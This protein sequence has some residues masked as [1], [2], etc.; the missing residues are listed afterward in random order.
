MSGTL[1]TVEE[2]ANNKGV[3]KSAV[4]KQMKRHADEL[5]DHIENRGGKMWLDE[6]AT[7]LLDEASNKSAPVLVDA[8]DKVKY[9]ELENRYKELEN[10][11]NEVQNK[12]QASMELNVSLSNEKT[13]MIEELTRAKA[14]IEEH[15][16]LKGRYEE[17][18]TAKSRTDYELESEKRQN[19][20]LKKELDNEKS[21]VERLKNRNLWQRLLNK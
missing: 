10:T 14:L 21:E 9:E 11:L 17:L 6:D 19:E 5:K 7:R 12:L 15:N 4:Y 3:T 20:E 2:Y 8:A 18:I 1:V 13:G 16:S